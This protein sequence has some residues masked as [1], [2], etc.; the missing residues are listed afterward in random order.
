M[1]RMIR[2]VRSDLLT[3]PCRMIVN[4]VNT[5]GVMGKGAALKFKRKYPA[6]AARYMARARAGQIVIG[7]VFVDRVA[8]G[9]IAYFPTKADWRQPSRLEYI[10]AG[11][12]SLV[13]M[14]KALDVQSIGIPALGC[15]A[16]G[17]AWAD[18]RPRIEAAFAVLPKVYVLLHV[19]DRNLH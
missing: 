12:V 11:L 17:L 1:A 3:S 6:S 15:G 4:P 18:V 8:Q 13:E 16:G 9:E 5:V 7:Q 14:V 10:D 2:V 19:P